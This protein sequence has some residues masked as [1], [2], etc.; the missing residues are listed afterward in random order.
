MTETSQMS[1]PSITCDNIER[2][3]DNIKR[4]KESPDISDISDR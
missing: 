3:Q 4:D 1:D 2:K